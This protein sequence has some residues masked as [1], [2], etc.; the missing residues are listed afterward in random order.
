[1]PLT[2]SDIDLVIDRNLA[3]FDKPGVLSVRPGLKVT[4]GLLHDE[5]AIVV[6]VHRK[7]ASPPGEMMLPGSI[8]GVPVDVR[9]ASPA[10]REQILN[11]SVY[12]MRM[13]NSPDLGAVAHF[14][15]ERTPWGTRPALLV[16]GRAQPASTA[17]PGLP[18]T[19]P[20]GVQLQ[21]VEGDVTIEASASPDSGWSALRS[22]LAATGTSL[23][24]GM[25][26]F[27]ARHV[28]EA[29]AQALHD[30][31]LKLVLDDL[32]PEPIAD[33]T[34]I[35]TVAE[36]DKELRGGFEQAWALTRPDP[37]ATAWIYQTSYHIKV[38][39]RDGSALWL[40]SGNWNNY[41]QPELEPVAGE[42]SGDKARERARDW[43]VVIHSADLA[44]MFQAY[45]LHDLVVAREHN[46][47][48]PPVLPS[49]PTPDPPGKTEPFERFFEAQEFCG[50]VRLTPVLTPDDGVYTSAV[51][52]L[53]ESA[54]QT[55]YMQYQYIELKSKS[56]VVIAKPYLELFEAVVAR[57]T[58]GVDVRIIMSQYE[59]HEYLEQLSEH[60]LTLT[61]VREQ[62]NVH[63]KGILVD[64]KK[65]LISSQNWSADGV[66]RNRDAGVIVESQ[67]VAGYFQ[68]IFLHDWDHLAKPFAT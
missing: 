62:P 8:E 52:Q 64:G 16:A 54:E 65:V 9:E 20:E 31:E 41:S 29:V 39:V 46:S 61:N 59:R 4:S 38:A 35:A 24:V 28:E 6:I 58:A 43:H 3:L 7:L 55:L 10:K 27:T 44:E 30:K 34:N 36:L 32:I 26:D 25:Y 67:P 19:P 33:D 53:I 14:A 42:Q 23:V 2:R 63:N 50:Q 40:S 18:Y 57:Q 37:Q 12:A 15:D 21:S 68:E 60:G 1:M 49:G 17:K 66:L 56:E 47:D 11:P 45:V 22:F 13:R 51:R 5:G 48:T